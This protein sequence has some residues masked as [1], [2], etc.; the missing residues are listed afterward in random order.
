V[1]AYDSIRTANFDEFI[2]FEQQENNHRIIAPLFDK[3]Y[4][5][6][7]WEPIFTL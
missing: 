3:A 6:T 1:Y 4:I 7:I 2:H 5:R